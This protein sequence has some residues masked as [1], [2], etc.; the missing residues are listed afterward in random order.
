MAKQCSNK[1]DKP[2][3]GTQLRSVTFRHSN[4]LYSQQQDIIAEE[5]AIAISYN[6]QSHAVMMASPVDLEDFAIGFSTTERIIDTPEDLTTIQARKAKQ[7]YTLN[8]Q[9]RK[10]LMQR[11]AG[12]QRIT[13]G[14]SSCG[15]CGISDLAEALPS[16]DSF[17]SS[18]TPDHS[19]IEKAVRT[20]HANQ[21]L[22]QQSGATHAAGLYQRASGEQLLIREDIGRHNA[23]D[24]LIGALT[25]QPSIKK[26]DCF[27]LMSS[28]ASHELISKSVIAGINTLV[29]ISAATSLAIE[30]AEKTN[31]NLIGFVRGKR[32]IIY[33]QSC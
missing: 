1:T 14:K 11:L 19:I 31:L 25:T 32:Q 8:L 3:E 2:L 7:G 18:P 12:K 27:I 15:V 28:R 20:L 33:A 17:K 23:L 21:A 30:L 4:T 9:I 29:T 26:S 16:L 6:G 13:S 22:Q 5:A 10:E 24:K